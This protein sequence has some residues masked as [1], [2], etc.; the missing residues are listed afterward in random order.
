MAQG[1][2]R[3]D[4]LVFDENITDN[5]RKFEKEWRIYCYAGLSINQRNIPHNSTMS[6]ISNAPLSKLT[7]GKIRSGRKSKE[8]WERQNVIE[9]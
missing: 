1:L 8:L 3:I 4:P 9:M 5:W 7:E 2:R 6:L